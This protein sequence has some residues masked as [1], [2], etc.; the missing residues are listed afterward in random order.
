M[1]PE[2]YR[3][4]L[5]VEGVDLE[6]SVVARLGGEAVG[7]VELAPRGEA[8]RIAAMGIVARARGRRLGSRLLEIVLEQCLLA[9]TSELRLEVVEGNVPAERL[10]RSFGFKPQ[11][12]LIGFER[13]APQPSSALAIEPG[14]V[15]RYAERLELDGERDLPWQLTPPTLVRQVPPAMLWTLDDAFAAV[16]RQGDAMTLQSLVVPCDARGDGLGRRLLESIL[17]SEPDRS[18]RVPARV[19]EG[20]FDG[21]FERCGFERMALSQ[22]EMCC[23]LQD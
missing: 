11:R 9:G 7:F 4:H 6:R 15:E 10:Y 22:Y 8:C 20:Y 13:A 5:R 16:M 18:W 1:T 17:A 19:P 3:H 2:L 21:F 23:S 14:D 12:R